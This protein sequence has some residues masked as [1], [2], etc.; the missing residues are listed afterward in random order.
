MLRAAWVAQELLKTFEDELAEVVLR[1]G[2][3]EYSP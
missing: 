3:A 1:P 2:G